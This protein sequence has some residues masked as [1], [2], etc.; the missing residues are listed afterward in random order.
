MSI[1]MNWAG[2]M[3]DPLNLSEKDLEDAGSQC[4]VTLPRICRFWGQTSTTYSVAQHVLSMVSYFEKSGA[5][6]EV[7]KMALFHELYE[8]MT[9]FDVPSPIKHSKAYLPYKEAEDKALAMFAKIKGLDP[10]MPDVIKEVDKGLMVK[11]GMILM[12]I[13]FEFSWSTYGEPCG[14]PY[15]LGASEEEIRNDFID[16]WAKYFP[17]DTIIEKK[18]PK[19]P[20]EVCIEC[21]SGDITI[22]ELSDHGD[23][24]SRAVSCNERDC[25]VQWVEDFAYFDYEEKGYL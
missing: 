22:G 24:L 6:E 3:I 25:G 18:K 11:E 14:V 8:G 20:P 1:V 5:N 15:R 16:A 21:E 10:V 4:A 23:Y 9:G 12:P 2:K 13:S 19:T 17:E 7:I